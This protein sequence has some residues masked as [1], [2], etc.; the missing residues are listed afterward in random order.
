MALTLTKKIKAKY[1]LWARKK[2]FKQE[3]VTSWYQYFRKNDPNID[4]R[5]DTV[6]GFYVGYKYIEI[7]ESAKIFE[8]T[9]ID[10]CLEKMTG[11]CHTNCK[12]KWRY[13]FH[14]VIKQSG[15]VHDRV[16]EF[17]VLNELG[18]NDILV[19]AFTDAQ[20]YTWFKL[21]FL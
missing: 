19:F 13:D 5:S 16:S 18:G 1:K 2:L 9:D 12:G 7:I 20:D 4:R 17:Y 10:Y 21:K 8:S 3:G 6:N 11:W 14:R 15:I